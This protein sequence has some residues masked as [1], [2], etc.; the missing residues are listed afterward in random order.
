MDRR[1]NATLDEEIR[2]IGTGDGREERSG[3]NTVVRAEQQ[4]LCILRDGRL[5]TALDPFRK[6]EKF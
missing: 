4:V 3:K 2:L 6:L 1:G 5:R